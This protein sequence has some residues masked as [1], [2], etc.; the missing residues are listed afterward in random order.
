MKKLIYRDGDLLSALKDAKVTAIGHQT[1]RQNTFGSGIAYAIKNM[2]PEAYAADTTAYRNGRVNLGDIS[3]CN[4]EQDNGP[5]L[6][7]FNLYGQDLFGRESR[8]TNYEALYCALEKMKQNIVNPVVG[9]PYKMGSDRG[10]GD[11]RIVERLIEVAFE[12]YNNDV[13]IYKLKE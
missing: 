13:V 8:K 6:Q 10:G 4:I 5:T 11:F 2:F 1:N 9:F 12:N 3:F 7:I